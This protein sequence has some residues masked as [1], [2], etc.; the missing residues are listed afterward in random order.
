MQ[1]KSCT[2]TAEKNLNAIAQAC[3]EIKL[4]TALLF[5]LG[6]SQSPLTLMHF[7]AKPLFSR[8]ISSAMKRNTTKGTK[9]NNAFVTQHVINLG[10]SLLQEGVG[11]FKAKKSLYIIT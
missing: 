3:P 8:L 6:M 7:S 9:R 5:F 4:C 11:P 10:N 1:P 2:I